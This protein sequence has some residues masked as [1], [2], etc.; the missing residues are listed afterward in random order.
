MNGVQSAQ[1]L[2]QHVLKFE[3]GDQVWWKTTAWRKDKKLELPYLEVTED[4]NKQ[5]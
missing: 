2:Q 5:S 1:R 3:V 4:S